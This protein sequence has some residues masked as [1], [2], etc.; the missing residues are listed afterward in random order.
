[1]AKRCH[2]ACCAKVLKSSLSVIR[3]MFLEQ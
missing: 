2:L 3:V 1:M